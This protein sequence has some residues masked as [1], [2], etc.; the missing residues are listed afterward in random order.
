MQAEEN[1]VFDLDGG[2][3]LSAPSPMRILV[4]TEYLPPFVSGIAN[5]CKNL[6]RGYRQHGHTVT[7]Y[8]PPGSDCDVQVVSIVNPFYDQQRMFLL[9][10][11]MLMLQCL[12]PFAEVPFDIAHIVGPLAFPFVFVVPL[13]RMRGV[14]IYVSYHVFLEFYKEKYFKDNQLLGSFLEGLFILFYFI[15]LVYFAD[16]VGVPSKTADYCVF[17]YSKRIHYMRSGLDTAVF[18]PTEDNHFPSEDD[19]LNPSTP[20]P[21]LPI[22]ESLK[23]FLGTT[24]HPSTPLTSRQT[25]LIHQLHTQNTIQKPSSASGSVTSPVLLYVGRLAVEKNCEFLIR[26]LEHPCLSTAR[27]VLVGDGPAR[28]S[29]EAVAREVV[30][31][32]RVYSAA[33]GTNHPHVNVSNGK[34]ASHPTARVLFA[35]MVHNE[36]IIRGYYAAADVFV[37]A[38]AS[39][40][41]G[42]TVAEALACG[43]PS[44]MVRSG[45]FRSVYRMIDGWMFEEGDVE[46]YVGRVGRVV[47]DGLLARRVSR[48]VAVRQFGVMGAVNDLLKTYDMCIRSD[49]WEENG[50]KKGG[51][52]AAKALAST[53]PSFHTKQE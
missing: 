50:I 41:F 27:L 24:A 32:E 23:P 6:V 16:V 33:A 14:R 43:T 10:P 37:S 21:P 17:R 48:R 11:F 51:S 31:A 40:T 13:L 38:S 12:N 42:F 19:Y 35:G 4:A 22:P 39:E 7:T 18:V 25:K 47:M 1:E 20:P 28:A 8:G 29:L 46:D 9:P 34:V 36:E 30:G 53:R 5:R 2:P 45:A 44:V 49:F 52:D 15:P 3:A 26:A